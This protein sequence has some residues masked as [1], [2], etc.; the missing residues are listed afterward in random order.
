MMSDTGPAETQ[1]SD[2]FE[3]ND[4]EADRINGKR[5][6]GTRSLHPE[7]HGRISIPAREDTAEQISRD[8][9]QYIAQ[10]LN[11]M[12]LLRTFWSSGCA[13]AGVP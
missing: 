12:R 3:T 8:V 2:G 11:W 9:R 5:S 4:P 7:G 6:G 10:R 13:C 1:Y